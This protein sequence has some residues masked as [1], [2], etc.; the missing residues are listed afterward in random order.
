M[1]GNGKTSITVVVLHNIQHCDNTS[2]GGWV[3]YPTEKLLYL[4]CNGAALC[5]KKQNVV[6]LDK[7]DKQEAAVL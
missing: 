2:C 3:S 1:A 7:H 6:M 4:I 5:D